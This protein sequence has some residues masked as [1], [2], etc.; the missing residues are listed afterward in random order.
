MSPSAV[1]DSEIGKS[2]RSNEPEQPAND[3]ERGEQILAHAWKIPVAEVRR[4]QR[5]AEGRAH[6]DAE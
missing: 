3:L 6:E 4:R 2:L 1:P 5:R